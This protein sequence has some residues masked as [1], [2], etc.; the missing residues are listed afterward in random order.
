MSRRPLPLLLTL[1]AA[2]CAAAGPAATGA[3]APEPAHAPVAAPTAPPPA[4]KPALPEKVTSVDGITEYR[5]ANGLR[6]LLFPDPTK[7]TVTVNI[8]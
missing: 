2:A 6:V 5:L 8:T 3:A 1:A 7:Q 4:P